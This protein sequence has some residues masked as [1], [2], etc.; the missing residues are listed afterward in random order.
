MNRESN[1]FYTFKF[2]TY[3]H[4]HM[5]TYRQA[6]TQMKIGMPGLDKITQILNVFKIIILYKAFYISTKRGFGF[7]TNRLN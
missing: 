7:L 1:L 3:T 5:H 2:N 6:I 4:R